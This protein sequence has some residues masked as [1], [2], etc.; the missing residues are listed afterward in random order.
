MQEIKQNPTGQVTDTAPPGKPLR[1]V[2]VN[3]GQMLTLSGPARPRVGQE[4][5]DLAIVN[6][7][8]FTVF[9]GRIENIGTYKELKPLPSPETEVIDAAGCAVLPGFV[10]AHTHIVFGGNRVAEFE[11][12]IAGKSYQEIA[13]AGGGILSTL[14]QTRDASQADLVQA[15]SRYVEWFLRG[16]TTTIEA[17][18]GYGLTEYSELKILNVV[19]ELGRSTPLQLVPTLLAAHTVPPEFKDNRSGY[20]SLIVDSL[21]PEAATTGLARYCDVFC[22][23]HAFTVD[24]ARV[25]FEAAQR[26]GLGLRMHAEQFRIDGGAQLAAE[27]GAQTA[28]HLECIDQAGMNALRAAGVQP[29]LLPASV[30]ALGR[31][32]YP[33]ARAMI[34]SGLAPVLASDF[35]PGSSPTT[36]MPFVISLAALYM[37]M[38]PSEAVVAATINAAASLE[39]AHEIG[40]LE[41]G[42]RANFVIHEFTDY[43]ELAYFIATP[44]MPRVFIAGR[45]LDRTHPLAESGHSANQ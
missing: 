27:L 43:R 6:D 30:F 11:Q 41:K 25:I 14:K 1:Y 16:G 19:R 40:S 4:L 15:A 13:A 10:D 21:I 28:D 45:E 35:N 39:L 17:K 24:E 23:D 33:D 18:S 44:A 32:A 8:C 7:A 2:V 26:H 3:C 20:V 22:D 42:K 37:K 31:T 38:L 34:A 12:R 9:D 36:S 5:Q 29:V